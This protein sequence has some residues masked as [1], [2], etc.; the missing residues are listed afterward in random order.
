MGMST[1]MFSYHDFYPLIKTIRIWGNARGQLQGQSPLVG[2]MWI[3]ERS[4][5][6]PGVSSLQRRGTEFLTN[7]Q[8]WWEATSAL[9]QPHPNIIRIRSP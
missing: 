3:P 9:H 8:I 5:V 7:L 4:N 6:S 1:A 2:E